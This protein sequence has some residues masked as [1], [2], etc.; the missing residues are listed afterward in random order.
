MFYLVNT[1]SLSVFRRNRRQLL[2][3]A[4]TS[5]VIIGPEIEDNPTV[6]TKP[7]TLNVP[8]VELKTVKNSVKSDMKWKTDQETSSLHK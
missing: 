5:P 7:V 6:V 2:K 8:T 1:P 3:T 4:E